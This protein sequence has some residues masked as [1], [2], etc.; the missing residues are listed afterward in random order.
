[1]TS[2][3]NISASPFRPLVFVFPCH[4]PFGWT[5]NVKLY[6]VQFGSPGDDCSCHYRPT[7]TCL[8]CS[9]MF[10]FPGRLGVWEWR[11][12]G[13]DFSN[14]VLGRNIGC[15]NTEMCNEPGDCCCHPY[16]QCTN[17]NKLASVILS[18]HPSRS[19]SSRRAL[20]WSHEDLANQKLTLIVPAKWMRWAIQHSSCLTPVIHPCFNTVWWQF[21]GHS[22]HYS[23]LSNKHNF[24]VWQ[25]PFFSPYFLAFY[26]AFY[27]VWNI[28]HHTLNVDAMSAS[29]LQH[30]VL[31]G[32]MARCRP[33]EVSPFWTAQQ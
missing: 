16:G 7:V 31:E 33:D 8:K 1:M 10:G 11:S 27:E 23:I 18:W 24:H 32:A 14:A 12:R 6:N 5:N 26:S 4:S 17:I 22:C 3:Q 20:E 28:C 25:N 21:S 2:C 19:I 13:S 9:T 29:L 30:A 15:L